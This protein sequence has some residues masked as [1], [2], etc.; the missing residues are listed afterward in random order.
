M[1]WCHR[2]ILDLWQYYVGSKTRRAVVD[3]F[4]RRDARRRRIRQWCA[5]RDRTMHYPDDYAAY[6][7]NPV[8][9]NIEAVQSL[10]YGSVEVEGGGGPDDGLR[11]ASRE[12]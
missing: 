3:A 9:S 1:R 5:G 2:M 6:M 12:W 8:G 10:L 4:Q 11:D 7:K